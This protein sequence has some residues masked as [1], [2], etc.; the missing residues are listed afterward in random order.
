MTG[1]WQFTR[2]TLGEYIFSNHEMVGEYDVLDLEY[3]NTFN[4]TTNADNSRGR[5]SVGQ[6][7]IL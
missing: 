3:L 2:D 6:M 4:E 7:Q 1:F 5:M